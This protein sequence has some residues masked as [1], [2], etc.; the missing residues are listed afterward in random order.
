MLAT[1]VQATPAVL[2]VRADATVAGAHVSLGDIAD[3][4]AL[5]PGLR[6]DA[7]GLPIAA[8]GLNET[9][10]ALS[11]KDVVGRARALMPALARWLPAGQG[12]VTVRRIPLS[13]SK[14]ERE[15]RCV[16]VMRSVT[17]GALVSRADFGPTPCPAQPAKGDFRYD[18]R[19]RD[20]RI[21]KTLKA[22]EVIAAPPASRVADVGPGQRL[23][24]EA[25][26]GPVVVRRLVQAIQPGRAGGS[27]FVRAS[28]GTV[29]SAPTPGA[30]Q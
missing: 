16:R 30:D 20:L 11:V 5:P 6:R 22:G 23:Y 17:S 25:T 15:A 19:V 26:V 9:K 8:F 27:L 14:N 29:F 12:T 24:V 18:L 3:V 2:A 7:A 28:D 21:S 1:T 13:T 10:L 4:S